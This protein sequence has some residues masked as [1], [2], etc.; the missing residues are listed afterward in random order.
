MDKIVENNQQLKEIWNLTLDKVESKAGK[1]L[2]DL[3]VRSINP[4]LFENDTLKLE[5]SNS[6]IYDNLKKNSLDSAIISSLSEI[7]GREIK[8]EFNISIKPEAKKEINFSVFQAPEKK[9]N[10]SETGLSPSYTFDEIL[11]GESNRFAIIM[12][13]K[14][15]EN[16][17]GSS[18][19]YFVYAPS[20]MGKTHILHAIGNEILKKKANAKILYVSADSFVDEFIQVIKEGKFDSFRT[21]YRTLDCLLL[22]DVQFIVKKERSE[23][24]FFHTFNSLFEYKKQIV[25][26]S[27]KAPNDLEL[28]ERLITRFKT[29]AIAD[30]KRPEYELRVAILNKENEKNNFRL[31]SDVINFIA[32]KVT[33]SIRSLKGCVTNVAHFCI[34][35][36][37]YPSIDTVENLVKDYIPAGD[38]SS[39]YVSI[40]KI[41]EE[42]AKAFNLN[43]SDINLKTRAERIS[44]PRQVAMYLACTLTDKSLPEI[45]EAFGK[46]HA[47]VIFAR[48]KVLQMIQTD[49]FFNKSINDIINKIKG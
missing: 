23:E 37:I 40:D 5:I 16:P 29:G 1:D 13:K 2:T 25:V 49:P 15:A 4:L 42:V 38:N 22:D 11:E 26:S 3:W 36:N 34:N 33:D 47:T 17:G 45:G 19:P 43:P 27:D 41:K 48:D 35:N 12:A 32:E 30:I 14:V 44:L 18:N 24:E 8:I 31:P 9:Q 46:N 7:L 21:K 10:Y 20:G 6:L 39:I 28:N